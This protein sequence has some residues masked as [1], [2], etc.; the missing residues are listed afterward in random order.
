MRNFI[1]LCQNKKCP[2]CLSV[3]RLYGVFLAGYKIRK[4]AHFKNFKR[5]CK[6]PQK[7]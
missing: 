7:M 6:L 4:L 3:A 1:S 5:I 2:D